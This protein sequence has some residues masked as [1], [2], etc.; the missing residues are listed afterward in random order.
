MTLIF[1][2]LQ[3]HLSTPV[4]PM[5]SRSIPICVAN[6]VFSSASRIMSKNTLIEGN[7]LDELGRRNQKFASALE[8]FNAN[9]INGALQ[10]ALK[11]YST[12]STSQHPRDLFTCSKAEDELNRPAYSFLSELLRSLGP[13]HPE[14]LATLAKMSHSVA[15]SEPFKPRVI[16]KRHGGYPVRLN[17]GKWTWQGPHWSRYNN[18]TWKTGYSSDFTFGWGK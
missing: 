12:E 18:R 13:N 11:E 7:R 1:V 4:F 10:I 2:G 5:I 9:D 3:I 15:E 8:L 17:N 6:R 14:T 16:K